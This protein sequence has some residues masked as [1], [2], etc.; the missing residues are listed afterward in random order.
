MIKMGSKLVDVHPNFEPLPLSSSL[1][2]Y[3]TLCR[4]NEIRMT[5]TQRKMEVEISGPRDSRPPCM[6]NLGGLQETSGNANH[7]CSIIT[8][9]EFRTA[10]AECV[11]AHNR[12]I[13][14]FAFLAAS[15]C[16]LGSKS[17]LPGSLVLD[18]PGRC[19]HDDSRSEHLISARR[20]GTT[21]SPKRQ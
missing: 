13:Y 19:A 5:G 20:R 1:P 16:G 7:D 4:K 3:T 12:H 10:T 6:S 17:R 9:E 21:G 11:S 2:F 18:D 14:R 15:T 8:I